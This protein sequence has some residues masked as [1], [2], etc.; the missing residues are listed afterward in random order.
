[1]LKDRKYLVN[2]CFFIS[3]KIG[4]ETFVRIWQSSHII[5]DSYVLQSLKIRRSFMKNPNILNGDSTFIIVYC[6]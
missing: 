2:I 5:W 4:G 3:H 1:M 6:N